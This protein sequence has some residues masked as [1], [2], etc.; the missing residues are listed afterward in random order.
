MSST[1]QT[2]A[3][4][5]IQ[6]QQ[7][8]PDH[9]N[10]LPDRQQRHAAIILAILAAISCGAL[11]MS[12]IMAIKIW[13]IDAFILDGGLLV[14]P[15]L[16]VTDDVMS[17]IFHQK[18]ANI[19]KALC[20]IV[21]V[22]LVILLRCT[23]FLPAAAGIES[24]DPSTALGGLPLR[25]TIASSVAAF[26][27]SCVNNAIHEHLHRLAKDEFTGIGSR[28]WWSSVVAHFPDSAIFTFL[29][30]GGVNTAFLGLCQQAVT[31]YIASVLAEIF[32]IPITVLTSR[33]IKRHLLSLR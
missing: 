32:L 10:F 7:P 16:Y 15:I 17:E 18:I 9:L 8:E 24:I 21:N 3:K 13:Q 14:F 4:A 29:A 6:P 1:H 5:F 33:T 12:N 31:S 27:S 30:F 28:A 11:C 20:C 19:V 2:P 25:I 26:I 22:V 23:M